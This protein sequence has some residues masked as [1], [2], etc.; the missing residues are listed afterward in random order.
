MRD[1]MLPIAGRGRSRSRTPSVIS[2][3][4]PDDETPRRQS[5]SAS[6]SDRR[7]DQCGRSASALRRFR[8]ASTWCGRNGGG[9]GVTYRR[10]QQSLDPAVG[11][12]KSPDREIEASF[13]RQKLC[14]R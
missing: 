6:N 4:T 2:D 8:R 9:R 1:L 13:E 7:G 5:R 14:N 12:E 10:K 11:K 3:V